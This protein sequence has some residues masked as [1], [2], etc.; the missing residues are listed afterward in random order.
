V[1][2]IAGWGIAAKRGK[3]GTKEGMEALEAAVVRNNNKKVGYGWKRSIG[4]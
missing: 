4:E 1:N 2:G 3:A